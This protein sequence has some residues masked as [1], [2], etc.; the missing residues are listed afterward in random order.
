MLR[1]NQPR[2]A[3]MV[4]RFDFGGHF[5]FMLITSHRIIILHTALGSS[6]M[7]TYVWI[8]KSPFCDNWLERY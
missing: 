2:H 4:D 6:Y 3:I 5:D 1:Y 8:Q 7:K